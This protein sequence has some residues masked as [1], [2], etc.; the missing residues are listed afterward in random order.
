MVAASRVVLSV[1]GV[2]TA[3]EAVSEVRRLSSLAKDLEARE[4]KIAEAK[5]TLE[6]GERKRLVA[7]L[8]KLGAEVPA[9]AWS[10]DT[11][12]APC[13][14]L[15]AEPIDELRARVQTLSAARGKAA[16]AKPPVSA[17]ASADGQVV[18][19]T[20]GPVALTGREVA[21]CKEYG[22]N[23]TAY[24]EAKAKQAKK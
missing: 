23:V 9:T 10:D 16:A 14:R 19:T 5:A 6:A 1:L 20:I 18:Q 4:A 11:A 24:A 2:A 22:T 17:D 12:S 7:E 21:I 13:K 3:D 15:Q 8:V